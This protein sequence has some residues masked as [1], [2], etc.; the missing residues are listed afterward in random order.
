[1]KATRLTLSNRPAY[2]CIGCSDRKVKCDRQDPCSACRKHNVQ[3]TFRPVQQSQKKQKRLKREVLID[4]LQHCEAFLK[5]QG[6]NPNAVSHP[7]ADQ[8]DESHRGESLQADPDLELLTPSS[9]ASELSTC[10]SKSRICSDRE[11]V[12]FVDK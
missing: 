4:R 9:V 7:E 3:C 1:M 10:L 5:K 11:R 2:S 8:P 6:L 12:K